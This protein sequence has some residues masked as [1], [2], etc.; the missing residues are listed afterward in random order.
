M[1]AAVIFAALAAVLLPAPPQAAA[2][3]NSMCPVKPKQKVK[4]NFT[5]VYEGQVIGFC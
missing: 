5:V 1:K 4:A 3:I 2:P